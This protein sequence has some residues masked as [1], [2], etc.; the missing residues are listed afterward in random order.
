MSIIKALGY[1]RIQA[2]DVAAW[3]EFGTKVLA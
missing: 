3:R 1:M 2:T